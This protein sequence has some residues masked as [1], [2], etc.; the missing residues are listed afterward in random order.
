MARRRDPDALTPAL[1][2]DHVVLDVDAFRR[3]CLAGYQ[4]ALDGKI[5]TFGIRPTQ[6]KTGYGYVLPGEKI[7]DDVFAVQSF[8]V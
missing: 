2:A 1:P 7:S 5:V 4:A 6:A 8:E 3:S